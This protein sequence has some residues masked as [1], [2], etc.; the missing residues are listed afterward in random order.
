MRYTKPYITQETSVKYLL[1][2]INMYPMLI[3]F[4]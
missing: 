2:E 3:P 1:N 4:T